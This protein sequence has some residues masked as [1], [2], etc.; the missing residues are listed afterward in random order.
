[1]VK[2]TPKILNKD[3]YCVV[4]YLSHRWLELMMLFVQLLS[5]KQY[6]LSS[7]ITKFKIETQNKNVNTVVGNYLR[8]VAA[9]LEP[10]I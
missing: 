10:N 5:V 2:I 9:N 3:N 6:C 1:L 7:Q 4:L 8:Y